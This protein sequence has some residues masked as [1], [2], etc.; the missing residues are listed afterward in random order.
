[1]RNLREIIESSYPTA[2][3]L[4]D[5]SRLDERLGL[6]EEFIKVRED[7]VKV[8]LFDLIGGKVVILLI[9]DI[10]FIEGTIRLALEDIKLTPRLFLNIPLRVERKSG[11]L[12]ALEGT[13]EE[14]L[15]YLEFADDVDS[16]ILENFS[17]GVRDVLVAVSYMV[18]DFVNIKRTV[19]EAIVDIEY[20]AELNAINESESEEIVLFLDWLKDDNFVFFGYMEYSSNGG[21]SVTERYGIFREGVVERIPFNYNEVIELLNLHYNDLVYA[22]KLSQKSFIHRPGKIDLIAVRMPRDDGTING[23]RVWVGLFT[24]KAVSTKGSVIPYIRRK[25]VNIALSRNVVY[26][27]YEYKQLKEVFDA[28]PIEELFVMSHEEID[29]IIKMIDSVKDSKVA[30]VFARIREK[31]GLLSVIVILPAERVSPKVAEDVKAG[32]KNMLTSDYVDY[33]V[34]IHEGLG[35]LYFFLTP[36]KKVEKEDI[37]RIE[38]EIRKLV[39]SW[40]D[41]FAKKLLEIQPPDGRFAKWVNF[42]RIFSEEYKKVTSVE[43][44]IIDIGIIEE[45]LVTGGFRV[46][47]LE[48]LIKVYSV[49]ALKLS[50]VVSVLESFY[51]TVIEEKAFEMNIEGRTVY[52]YHYYV[53]VKNSSLIRKDILDL[54]SEAI[55][56]V[57]NSGMESD[58]LNGLVVVGGLNWREVDLLRTYRNYLRQIKPQ[59]TYATTYNAFLNYS[60]LVR[61]LVNLFGIKFDPSFAGSI[62]ERKKLFKSKKEEFL[63]LLTTIPTLAEEKVFRTYLNLVEATT[64]TN[65]FKKKDGNY[66]SVKI[67]CSK[68]EDLTGYKPMFETYVHSV[69]TEAVHLRAGRIARGG[70][71]W[72]DRPDDFRTEIL[73]LMKTQVLKNAII[74][75]TG[76]KG[77]FVVKGQGVGSV[78]R[79]YS[80][81]IKGLLDITDNIVNSEIKKPDDVVCYD[82]DDYYLVVAADKGTARMSDLANSI[83]KSYGYWLGDAFASGGSTGY[84]HKKFGVT[85][86]GAWICVKRHLLEIGKN[87]DRDVITVVGIGDMSGDVFGNGMIYS[88]NI[89]LIAAFNHRYIFVDPDPDLEA[90]YNERLRL[91]REVRDWDGYNQELISKG[92]FVARRDARAI[93]LSEETR[94]V[95][96]V[97]E[98]EVSGEELIKLI[99]KVPA[100]L[101]WNGGVGTYVKAST[102]TNLEVM[103]PHN[104]SVRVDA[105]DLKV[106][107]VGEGGNLGF[108]QKARIEYALNGGKINMDSVD[109][110]AGV[111]T[112][113]YE[114]NIKILLN[115]LV[116]EG[117]I[118]E[119]DRLRIIEDVIDEVLEKV[120]A[121]NYMQ[122][123]A[124][125]LDV[126]RSKENLEDFVIAV[127]D[128]ESKRILDRREAVLPSKTEFVHRMNS[129]IGLTRPEVAQLISYEKIWV[130]RSLLESRILDNPYMVSFLKEYFPPKI[131]ES[132]GGYLT[133]HPLKREIIATVVTN[134]MVDIM[135][136]TFVHSMGYKNGMEP[137]EVAV[138]Y[139]MVSGILD[140]DNYI[141]MISSFDGIVEPSVQY[142]AYLDLSKVVSEMV[143]WS[144]YFVGD[145]LP[146]QNVIEKYRKMVSD[147]KEYKFSQQVIM[148]N[149][150]IRDRINMYTEAGFDMK[151]AK[152]LAILPLLVDILDIITLSEYT[153]RPLEVTAHIYELTN[154]IFRITEIDRALFEAGKRD[155]WDWQ[156][157][158]YLRRD[159]FMTRRKLVMEMASCLKGD[160]SQDIENVTENCFKIWK[161]IEKEIEKLLVSERKDLIPWHVVIS[162]LRDSL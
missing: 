32:L 155:W 85:A 19:R 16:C 148:K 107:V 114:V 42:L 18:K 86:K 72:S 69:N 56:K 120:F 67:D 64:R 37:T 89:K 59:I 158:R 66:I 40:D 46:R 118:S 137:H 160:M 126:M 45:V 109:N 23:W 14:M 129:K 122:S 115:T 82:G 44:A 71:R 48:N 26:G 61:M 25:L 5:K 62:E 80:D 130:K 13:Q 57:L 98:V 47:A 136:S 116:S 27:S 142:R 146:M 162:K 79:A 159:L 83:A 39:F 17:T 139:I 4:F 141:G 31:Q 97:N 60:S 121:N 29:S 12:V 157:Y 147:L 152:E 133:K 95:L 91:F 117:V 111:N 73:G 113:D 131:V 156:F 55:E 15:I 11:K 43:E 105:R 93:R 78:E 51:L 140:V 3:G 161:V 94:K 52:L 68:L 41:L 63:K 6:L 10:P 110:S 81:F 138:T 75:P 123:L 77:G 99:L 36:Y 2:F 87:I 74:V 50:D 84:D 151:V 112:S 150:I 53:N 54:L 65:F 90:S 134:K 108:T 119:E 28:I 149:G 100:D 127:D 22:D 58:P 20:L 24:R 7:V 21:F 33:R 88:K 102:E 30:N 143:T 49:N 103:D 153:G 76:A 9:D 96:G 135:G 154:R 144:S 101:L 104:D 124:I 35:I 132:Y 125:S 145:W 92:G 38:E 70:I 1:M 128:L 34:S 106:K 8:G